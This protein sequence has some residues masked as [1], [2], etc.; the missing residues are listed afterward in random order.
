MLERGAFGVTEKPASHEALAKVFGELKTHIGRDGGDALVLSG[1]KRERK[2][3][4]DALAADGLSVRT[5]DAVKK[6]GDAYDLASFRTIVLIAGSTRTTIAEAAALSATPLATGALIAVVGAD[7]GL[8]ASVADSLAGQGD[9]LIAA[10]RAALRS[11]LAFHE[12]AIAREIPVAASEQAT[13]EL[14]GAKV[15]IVD[16]D[17]RNIYSLTSVLE[18]CGVACVH[19]ERGRDG[20]EILERD[21]DIDVALIDIMMPEMD[22]YETMREIR[23][24]P[25]LADLPLIS[26]T[27]KAMKG[28]RQKCLD[29]GA[30]DYIAKPVDIDLLRA[31]LRVWVARSRERAEAPP[32]RT[33]AE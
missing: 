20:I 17:I 15:L 19:A 4:A 25:A 9:V 22:G 10:D 31:L 26:V 3:V 6:A 30:S 28:D 1:G 21:P 7:S 23:K 29:A 24:R 13:V 16:D 14:S 2:A 8:A 11:A 32:L 12:E 18:T 33:A 5:S 27:A